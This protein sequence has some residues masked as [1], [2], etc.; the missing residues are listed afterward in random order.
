VLEAVLKH[1]GEEMAVPG[2]GRDQAASSTAMVRFSIN[3][4]LVVGAVSA[5]NARRC[6]SPSRL[7]AA[8]LILYVVAPKAFLPLQ[9]HGSSI[10]AVTQAGPRC[11][12]CRDAEPADRGSGARSR[13]IP[14][15]TGRRL[16]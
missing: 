7:L 4:T 9:D 6:S 5:N 1:A 14:D 2:L 16:P 3:R 12:L 8:T 15:V 11:L 13:P 10:T